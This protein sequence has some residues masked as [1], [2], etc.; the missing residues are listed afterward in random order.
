MTSLM[1]VKSPVDNSISSLSERD[2][3]YPKMLFD[4]R[5][6]A[7]ERSD[8]ALPYELKNI[9]SP[10]NQWETGFDIIYQENKLYNLLLATQV[11]DGLLIKPGETFSLW[12]NLGT[13]RLINTYREGISLINGRLAITPAGGMTVMSTLLF[14]LFLHSP[15]TLIER[16][17]QTLRD[18]RPNP[19][20]GLELIGTEA[21]VVPGRWDLKVRNDSRET[22]QIRLDVDAENLWGYLFVDKNLGGGY[23]LRNG[24]CRYYRRMDS[25]IEQVSLYQQKRGGHRADLLSEKLL[26]INQCRIDYELPPETAVMETRRVAVS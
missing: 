2:L 4:P 8:L 18:T 10:L 21:M 23:A 26:F 19:S 11:L 16:H 22:F 12:K 24:E 9:C 6:Y 17:G 7:Q 3:F 5:T 15:L 1:S 20:D 13:K 25:I 14:R